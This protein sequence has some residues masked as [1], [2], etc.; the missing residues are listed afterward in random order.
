MPTLKELREKRYLSI[1]ELANKSGIPRNTIY[2][3]ENGKH[4]PIRRTIRALAKALDILPENFE[5]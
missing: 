1:P 4:K 5:Y 3:I 2:G